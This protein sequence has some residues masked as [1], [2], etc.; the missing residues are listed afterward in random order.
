MT[1]HSSILQGTA[2]VADDAHPST[3]GLPDRW[4][5]TEEWYNFDRNMRGSVHVLVTADETTYDAGPNKMGADH[6]ISWC[7]NPEGARVWATAMGHNASSYS[8][9]LFRQHLLGAVQWA[10]GAAAGDCGGTVASRF[11]KVTLDG[12]PDQPMELDV[13]ADGRVFYISRSGKVN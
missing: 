5:R 8:E 10:A 1:A 11:Q 6:P 3:K 9:P 4:A 13:A 7:H 12:A 2:K